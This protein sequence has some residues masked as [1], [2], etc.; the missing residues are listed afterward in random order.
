MLVLNKGELWC[1]KQIWRLPF[2][3][4]DENSIPL[5]KRM[6]QW[7]TYSLLEVMSEWISSKV[8]TRVSIWIN[9][10]YANTK[11]SNFNEMSLTNR[12]GSS[13]IVTC[14][15]ALPGNGSINTPWYTHATIGRMFVARC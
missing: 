14:Q 10:A 9:F 2:C 12:I 15:N 1:N 6:F 3:K 5:Q 7:I 13:I 11:L 4:V 8:Y